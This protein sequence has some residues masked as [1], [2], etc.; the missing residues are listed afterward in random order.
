MF[1]P[2]TMTPDVARGTN[3][4]ARELLDVRTRDFQEKRL[5]DLER[6]EKRLDLRWRVDACEQFEFL[7]LLAVAEQRFRRCWKPSTGRP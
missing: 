4:T 3:S 7:A 5:V 1:Q 2:A 6:I